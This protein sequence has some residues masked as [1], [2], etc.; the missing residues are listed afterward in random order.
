MGG[1]G[2]VS[3]VRVSA[4]GGREAFAGGITAKQLGRIGK[5]G[6]GKASVGGKPATRGKAKVKSGK[7]KPVMGGLKRRR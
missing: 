2:G 3:T 7:A 4:R 5:K 6:A 1:R